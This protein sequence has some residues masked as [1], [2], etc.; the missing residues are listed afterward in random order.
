MKTENSSK[1]CRIVLKGWIF[2]QNL[3]LKVS[4]NHRSFFKSINIWKWRIKNRKNR[5]LIH[6]HQT[7]VIAIQYRCKKMSEYDSLRKLFI[8]RC[9]YIAIACYILNHNVIELKRRY[10]WLIELKN[11]K[12]IRIL[13]LN[14][15]YFKHENFIWSEWFKLNEISIAR[16]QV[17]NIQILNNDWLIPFN[18]W[19]PIKRQKGDFTVFIRNVLKSQSLKWVSVA[20]DNDPSLMLVLSKLNIFD[21]AILKIQIDDV[22]KVE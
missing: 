16:I 21:D 11:I 4:S 12:Q 19:N 2:N 13:Q 15:L 1:R 7:I 6:I 3:R 14:S 10:R 20:F 8:W 22:S 9:E 17:W 5:V 18:R